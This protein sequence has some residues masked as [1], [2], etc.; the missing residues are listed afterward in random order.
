MPVLVQRPEYEVA[1]QPHYTD[2]SWVDF[3]GATITQLEGDHAVAAGVSIMST[4]GHTP[5]HQSVLVEG[6]HGPT[7]LVG[8]AFTQPPISKPP[9]LGAQHPDRGRGNVASI[10]AAAARNPAAPCL[11]QSR[12]HR[13]AAASPVAAPRST[14]DDGSGWSSAGTKGA[15]RWSAKPNANLAHTSRR[16]LPTL[17]P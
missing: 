8:Q 13:M 14:R 4:P 11:L 5:G 6:D 9:K 10:A 3:A 16:I 12:R 2:P 15:A 1:H 17:I 7:L